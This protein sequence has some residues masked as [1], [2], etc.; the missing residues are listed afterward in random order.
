MLGTCCHKVSSSETELNPTSLQE[1]SLD[2]EWGNIKRSPTPTITIKAYTDG[3]S[4]FIQHPSPNSDITVRI[5]KENGIV[6]CENEIPAIE[7]T[8][9]LIPIDTLPEGVYTLEL[10]N[11]WGNYLYGSFVREEDIPNF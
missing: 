3:Y 9:I 5:V 7:T 11:K 4:I 10:T 2:G 6:V 8:Y 1:L